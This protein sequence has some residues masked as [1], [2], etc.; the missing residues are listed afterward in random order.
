[1]SAM[2]R[3][4]LGVT[5]G[6]LRAYVLSILWRWFFADPFGLP[7][8][9]TAHVYGM[10]IITALLGLSL[11]DLIEPQIDKTVTYRREAAYLACA[12][13]SLVSLLVGYIVRGIM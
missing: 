3:L 6:V 12:F 5:E 8:I 13:C 10:T 7:V 9:G 2:V 11:V 4:L 1:M